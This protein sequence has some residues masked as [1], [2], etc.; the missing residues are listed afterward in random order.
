VEWSVLLPEVRGGR[1]AR[2]TRCIVDRGCSI[3]EGLVVGEDPVLDAARFNRTSRG[4][5]L[6]TRE[7]L[8]RLG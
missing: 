3:P 4:V 2:L 1:G 8:S 7:M 5:T 6:I